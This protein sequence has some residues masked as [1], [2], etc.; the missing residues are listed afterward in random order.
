MAHAP[1]IIVSGP[2]GSGKS[3]LIKGVIARWP[4]HLRL[5]ASAT[6]RQP[7]PGEQEGRDY[8]FWTR[9][10]FQQGIEAGEFLE[11]ACVHGQHYYGT[12]R[13]QVAELLE[14]GYGVFLDIDVQGAAKVREAF[15]HHLSVFVKLPYF[16]TYCQRLE[17]RG[18]KLESI[19]RR[20]Q[21]A[22]AEL[23][24]VGEYQHVIVN[25]EQQRATDEMAELVRGGFPGLSG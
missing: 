3:T 5:A 20:L 8:F 6:T 25:D 10:R 1:L 24:H 14:K 16:W 19:V 15:P 13:L 11:Y 22:V 17:Y 9:E 2:S 23:G 18:E 4:D 21:T 12:P 7:R